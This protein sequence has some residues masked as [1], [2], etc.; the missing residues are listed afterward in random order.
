[1]T[2]IEV[3]NKR[4]PFTILTLFQGFNIYKLF[5]PYFKVNIHYTINVAFKCLTDD[6]FN[7]FLCEIFLYSVSTN[8]L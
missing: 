3:A 1:M 2:M 5:H 6:S 7:A 4:K 8:K